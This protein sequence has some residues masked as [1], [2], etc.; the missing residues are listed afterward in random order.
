DT[1]LQAATVVADNGITMMAGR[2]LTVESAQNYRISSSYDASSK[3]GMIGTWYNP[4]IGNIKGSQANAEISTTQQASQVA[5]LAGN[6][7]M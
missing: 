5:S 4:A 6:V 1:T 3:S 7:T 2:N